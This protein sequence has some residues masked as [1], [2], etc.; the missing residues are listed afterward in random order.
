MS[1]ASKTMLRLG[2]RGPR[3]TGRGHRGCWGGQSTGWWH[4]RQRSLNGFTGM[5]K[6]FGP[7]GYLRHITNCSQSRRSKANCTSWPD[8][9]QESRGNPHPLKQCFGAIVHT[10]DGVMQ[11]VISIV[12][13]FDSLDS[14]SG[15][16]KARNM[17]WIPD[18]EIA[19]NAILLII[20]IARSI[21]P[22]RMR[23][24]LLSFILSWQESLKTFF[25]K[26]NPRLIVWLIPLRRL[27]NAG[28]F[29]CGQRG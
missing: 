20:D 9:G 7:H 1:V 14:G 15:A 18:F 4:I 12:N 8:N 17:A 27:E 3:Q 13:D 5:R 26:C 6:M 11:S 10:I 19:G 25:G 23:M 16:Y 22:R 24:L 21:L 2:C 29:F 28:K